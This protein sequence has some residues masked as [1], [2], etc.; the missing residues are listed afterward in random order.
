[1]VHKKSQQRDSQVKGKPNTPLTAPTVFSR[2][3]QWNWP[4]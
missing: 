3:S 2:T 4:I 1:M